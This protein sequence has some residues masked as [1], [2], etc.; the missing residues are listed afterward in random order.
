M[1]KKS[2]SEESKVRNGKR[3][4]IGIGYRTE[5]DIELKY[6][7]Q[8]KV[9]VRRIKGQDSRTFIISMFENFNCFFLFITFF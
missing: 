5:L 8:I 6:G 1:L 9:E 7:I 4:S 2:E 3:E